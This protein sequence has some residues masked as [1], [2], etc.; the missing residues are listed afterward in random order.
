MDKYIGV[1]MINAES[2]VH[3][4]F[5]ASKGIDRPQN[6]GYDDKGYK[7]VY[8]D[9]YESWSPKRVFEKAYRRID[10][11][12]F[13]LAIEA[14]KI[15]KSVCRK[16]WNGKGMFLILINPYGNTQ[17]SIIEKQDM[18][19]TLLPY[20]AIK[21]ADNGIIPW[22]ASQIDVLAEDWMVVE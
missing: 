8:E 11:M 1:K 9:D 7:V 10:N 18:C 17:Y 13:G 15:G 12:T 4:K 20:I 19:G 6:D 21:T 14:L 5:E 3:G 16:G 2:M 22:L